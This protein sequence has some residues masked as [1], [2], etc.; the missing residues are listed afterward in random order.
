MTII[1]NYIQKSQDHGG[2]WKILLPV[3]LVFFTAYLISE[4]RSGKKHFQDQ[5]HHQQKWPYDILN[6]RIRQ[7]RIP[8]APPP[9]AEPE[10]PDQTPIFN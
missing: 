1:L 2:A 6:I 4:A 9:G 8:G 5:K 10:K 3:F 7:N